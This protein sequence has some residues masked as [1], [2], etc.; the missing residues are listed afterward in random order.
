MILAEDRCDKIA[1][2]QMSQQVR[3]IRVENLLDCPPT[4]GVAVSAGR[5]TATGGNTLGECGHMSLEYDPTRCQAIHVGRLHVRVAHKPGTVCSQFIAAEDD[6]IF[7]LFH[8][9]TFDS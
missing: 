7:V 6:Q 1:L 4:I 5:Q 9:K 8:W 2:L 3:L